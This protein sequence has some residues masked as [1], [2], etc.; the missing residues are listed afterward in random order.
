MHDEIFEIIYSIDKINSS[1]SFWS[2]LRHPID[3][4]QMYFLRKKYQVLLSYMM[5]REIHRS[6][7]SFNQKLQ[8]AEQTLHN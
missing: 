2:F 1:L 4:L 8:Q 7:I 3:S 5:E 6:V